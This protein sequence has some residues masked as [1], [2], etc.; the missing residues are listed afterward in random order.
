MDLRA[1]MRP[2]ALRVLV[3]LACSLLCGACGPLS[4]SSSP[5]APARYALPE[6]PASWLRDPS[7]GLVEVTPLVLDGTVADGVATVTANG[8]LPIAWPPGFSATFTPS[9]VVLSPD[10]SPF[11]RQGDDMTGASWHGALV[12]IV[13]LQAPA[14][15]LAVWIGFR[16]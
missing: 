15:N 4:S 8:R 10:G 1:M 12:C 9:L 14:G 16:P 11:A 3:L 7:C 2:V 5:A 6:A 13:D